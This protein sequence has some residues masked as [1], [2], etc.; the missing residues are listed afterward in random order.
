M[1]STVQI[2]ATACVMIAKYTP[3]TRR[4]N[5]A[6]LT[7]QASAIGASTTSAR[8]SG[9]LLNGSHSAGNSV[10]WFQSMKSGM[11]GV[12]WILVV[13]GSEASSLRNIAIA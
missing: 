7:S 2:S 9:R 12:D 8:L 4:L 3:P 6:K 5:I 10:I 13:M 1:M 11:P